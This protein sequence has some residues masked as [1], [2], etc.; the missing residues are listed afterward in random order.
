MNSFSDLMRDAAERL[1]EG[2]PEFSSYVD[3]VEDIL[4]SYNVVTSR[5]LAVNG[6]YH[7][8]IAAALVLAHES[9][10][11]FIL[12]TRYQGALHQA[13]LSTTIVSILDKAVAAGL[14]TSDD[15]NKKAKGPL[16]IGELISSYLPSPATV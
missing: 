16:H 8:T 6:E 1:S 7:R 2:N 13:G 12:P 10:E 15:P 3:V 5:R 9:A 14:I 11:P 4:R